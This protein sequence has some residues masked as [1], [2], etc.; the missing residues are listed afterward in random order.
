[1]R[2]KIT[3]GSEIM[4]L[5]FLTRNLMHVVLMML[6]IRESRPKVTLV[7]RMVASVA[8]YDYIMDWEFQMDG[9]VRIKVCAPSI[10]PDS[11]PLQSSA[12]CRGE[13]LSHFPLPRPDSITRAGLFMH[14]LLQVHITE[15]H[16]RF[17]CWSC[18]RQRSERKIP[19]DQNS[20]Q[21]ICVSFLAC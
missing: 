10:F 17:A 15:V 5:F 21:N 8:N 16:K 6:Q 19:I 20:E 2:Q 9:L 1:M 18:W 14:S 3:G 12:D 4:T 13:R 11:D 7:A